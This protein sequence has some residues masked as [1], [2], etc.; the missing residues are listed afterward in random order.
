MIAWLAPRIRRVN[1]SRFSASSV[2]TETVE[3]RKSVFQGFCA[4]ARSRAEAERF[5][6]ALCQDD[7]RIANA[8]HRCMAFRLAAGEE[9][10]GDDDGEKGAWRVMSEQLTKSDALDTV[11][12]VARWYGGVSLGPARFRHI[13]E[14]ARQAIRLHQQ[15]SPGAEKQDDPSSSKKNKRKKG[16]KA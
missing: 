8:T 6:Q 9:I 5:V 2:L 12:V 3:D 4:P 11:V 13:R 15:E 16:R 10:G 1:A 14:M 7:K